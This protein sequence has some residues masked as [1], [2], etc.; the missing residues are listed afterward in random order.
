MNGSG[1]R[2]AVSTILALLLL[3][4]VGYQIYASHF[5]R[6][7]TESAYSF[8]ASSTVEAD[9]MAIRRETVLKAPVRGAV[10]YTIEEGEKVAK[11]ETVA[12]IYAGEKQ[13]A[14]RTEMEELDQEISQLKSLQSP[15]STYAANPAD[16]NGRICRKLTD[17]IGKLGERDI[18]GLSSD[19]SGL[20]YLLNEKQAV[21]G[22]PADFNA[23]ISALQKARKELEKQAGKALGS[24]AAPSSGYFTRKTDSLESSLNLENVS[25]YSPDDVRRALAAG[26]KPVSGALGRICE[27]YEWYFVCVVPAKDAADFKQISGRQV[28]VRLPFVS[29]AQVSAEVEKVNRKS[30]DSEAA[31]ILRCENM[32][33]ELASVRKEEAQIVLE[34]YT[35]V[36][37][38][39]KAV[40]YAT[41]TAKQK[42]GGKTET[43]RKEVPGV[44]VLRGGQLSFRQIVPKYST[45]SYV[46]CGQNPPEGSILT[47]STV[48]LY[49]EVVVEGTDLY[50]GKVVE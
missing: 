47:D 5:S 14:A 30:P 24:V 33:P 20:L 49:D 44:Y 9:V 28:S 29:G 25:S 50:D 40:H 41:V 37:V 6:I 48:K 45:E 38:S 36:R 34:E 18:S 13:A 10:D 22:K 31:V 42:T 46:I 35:G 11:G 19:R 21:S 23:R 3:F 15:G 12:L 32:A 26:E 17:L 16:A 39:R 4:Y 8:T 27:G 1:G 7:R 43:V 2:K